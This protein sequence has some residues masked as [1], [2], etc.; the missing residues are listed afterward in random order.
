MS[1]FSSVAVLI[2]YVS[3]AA[4]MLSLFIPQKR[5]RKI[6]SFV[7][8]LFILVAVGNGIRGLS[9]ELPDLSIAAVDLQ[10][11]SY[12]DEYENVIIQKTAD[13][14]VLSIDSLLKDEGIVAEDIRLSLKK[15]ADNSISADRVVIYISDAYRDRVE[16]IERIVVGNLS[17]EPEVYVTSSEA[18]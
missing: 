16:E 7:L 9:F 8:G 15:S 6:L 14:L 12:E 10:Q 17:K 5:T 11:S 13:R 2:C 4:T 3:A 1:G 18:R